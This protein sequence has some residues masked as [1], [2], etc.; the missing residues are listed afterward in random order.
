MLAKE[1]ELV[2]VKERQLA[3][4]N[5]VSE[6]ENLQSQVNRWLSFIKVANQ[7]LCYI[8][9]LESHVVIIADLE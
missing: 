6:M 4:E 3:A 5:R 1:E 7:L 2:K 9:V 8:Y